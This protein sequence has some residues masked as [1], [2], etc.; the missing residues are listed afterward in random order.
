M[1]LALGCTVKELKQRMDV[2]EFMEWIAYYKISP[3]GEERADLR[4]GIIAAAISNPFR[5]KNQ[6]ASKPAD[7]M[8]DYTKSTRKKTPEEMKAIFRMFTI[9]SKGTIKKA[10]KAV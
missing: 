6:R 4:A 7:F 1:A 10:P 2:R 5:S 9:A 8:P 3:F